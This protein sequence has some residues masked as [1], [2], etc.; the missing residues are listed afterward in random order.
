MTSDRAFSDPRTPADDLQ[1]EFARFQSDVQRAIEP[2]Q[3]QIMLHEAQSSWQ[4]QLR[5]AGHAAVSPRRQTIFSV[6]TMI[7]VGVVSIGVAVVAIS[8]LRLLGTDLTVNHSFARFFEA[9]A[10]GTPTNTGDFTAP[11][12][13]AAL[14]SPV[15]SAEGERGAPADQTMQTQATQTQA[16]SSDAAPQPQPAELP[17]PSST[18]DDKHETG[19]SKSAE[20]PP[21][22]IDTNVPAPADVSGS[23]AVTMLPND[24]LERFRRFSEEQ[25]NR[26][27]VRT[28]QEQ[29][30]SKRV[31]RQKALQ[32]RRAQ[33]ARL[34]LSSH[35]Q[36]DRKDPGGEPRQSARA[37]R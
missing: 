13:Q 31:A 22:S 26:D 16:T 5:Q 21:S 18:A 34:A 6:G 15:Q 37:P 30:S 4:E 25:A 17:P 33:A 1:H 19:P 7:R 28:L 35:N 8:A 3:N 12:D 29:S 27:K 36:S 20:A 32:H 10:P 23:S 14:P 11:P 24:E 9:L 2:L